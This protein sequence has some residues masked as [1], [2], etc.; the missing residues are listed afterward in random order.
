[1][2]LAAVCGSMLVTGTTVRVSAVC[3]SISP[4]QSPAALRRLALPSRFQGGREGVRRFEPIV[5]EIQKTC[6]EAPPSP[7]GLLNTVKCDRVS[8]CGVS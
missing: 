8:I 4:C 5:I 1:M 6:L 2:S 3:A 7:S